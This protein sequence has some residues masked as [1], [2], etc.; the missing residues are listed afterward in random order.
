MVANET[1]AFA[2]IF[3]E[4]IIMSTIMRKINIIS[5]SECVY[6]TD[7]FNNNELSGC[8]HTYIL[9][10]CSNPGMTQDELARH[11]SVNKSNVARNLN[12]LEETGY[13]RRES[14]A[15]DRRITNVYPT[16]KM[17]DIFPEIK[18]ISIE[19]NSYLAA[20]ISA[21]EFEQ[22]KTILDKLTEKATFY[23]NG[24]ERTK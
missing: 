16:Q 22:F 15:T 19:W 18:A 10:I 24:R 9:A 5:R 20:G 4:V 11:I 17:L 8:H 23:I 3:C 7:R 14:C 1:V 21:N 2:T 6:R 13:V 12:Y